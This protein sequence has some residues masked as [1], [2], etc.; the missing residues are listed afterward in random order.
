[1]KRI[2]SIIISLL[3]L[4]AVFP[5]RAASGEGSGFS[6]PIP[7]LSEGYSPAEGIKAAVIDLDS[8]AVLGSHAGAERAK[9]GSLSVL[10]TAL[11]LAENTPDELWDEP[12]PPLD[13]VNSRWTRRASQMGL[14]AGMTPTRRDLL[15]GLMLC[16]AAD[17]AFVT[18]K[19]VSGGET[20]F[21]FAMNARAAELGLSGTRFGNS[22]GLGA[23]DH[24]S[25]ALDLA[26][27]TARAMGSAAIAEAAAALE[28]MCS[29]GCGNLVIKNGNTALATPGSLGVKLGSDSEK[30]HCVITAAGAGS[31]R[32]A[33]VVLE[34]SSDSE[35]YY[36]AENLLGSAFA[37]Y[38]EECGLVPFLPANALY[39]ASKG[40]E[41][42]PVGMSSGQSIPLNGGEA[43]R[44]CGTGA[45][46]VY[47][48]RGG[49]YYRLP[50][51]K[52][53]FLSFVDDV[54]IDNG[55]SL[56]RELM[57]GERLDPAPRI[58]TRHKV[59][60]VSIAL[61]LPGGD[62]VFEG[63]CTIGA[64]GTVDIAGT[65]LDKQLRS[66]AVSDGIFLCELT[67]TVH[68]SAGSE[69]KTFTKV[70]R[71][72]LSMGTGGQCVSFNANGGDGAPAGECFMGSFTI[73]AEA[74]E[75][76]GCRFAGWS[77]SPEGEASYRAG[78]T[79]EYADSLTLYAVWQPAAASWRADI[80]PIYDGGLILEGI[81]E[82]PAGIAKLELDVTNS[83]GQTASLSAS[84]GA[85][86]VTPS[87]LAPDPFRLSADEYSLRLYGTDGTGERK[88]LF[89][90]ELTV[91]A[92]AT[93]TPEASETPAPTE[94]NDRPGF[95]FSS[96]PIG[97]WFIIGAAV[98]VALITAIVLIIKNG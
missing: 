97:V 8:G 38:Q 66:Y 42:E 95:S 87:V 24:Y 4:S 45:G 84:A 68:C 43:L 28:Y 49:A 75:R 83:R 41:L 6:E 92:A 22:Y 10:M 47:V 89:E 3:V 65:E 32:L 96:V 58:S 60:S 70:S 86:S 30:E 16:G 55:A 78:D 9:P 33:A 44:V 35:A 79:V 18:A 25:T 21:V 61:Y 53:E 11:L 90:G 64:H 88:L 62:R 81:I 85:N 46:F 23:A 13:D 37:S 12:L 72:L 67:V 26:C 93:E 19:L 1:M 50:E 39:L 27:L 76:T 34:A 36:A 5:A 15:Y 54:F 94:R 29:A 52:A 98:V 74:P 69:Q 48:F 14:A 20:E 2:L 71:S 63:S 77:L 51:G 59:E 40:A 31:L 17:A 73:P 80:R 57:R 7:P 91:E 82:N 56:S